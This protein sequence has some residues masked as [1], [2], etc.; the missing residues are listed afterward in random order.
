MPAKK[1]IDP[2][3]VEKLAQ[4]FCSMGEIAAVVGCDKSTISR[5]FA[6][7][8]AKGREKGK[9]LL[10]DLQWTAAKKGNIA[11]LIWLGKQFLDQKEKQEVHATGQTVLT[12]AEKIVT[13]RK[14]AKA[15]SA[16]P[17]NRIDAIAGGGNGNGHSSGD[18]PPPDSS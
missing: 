14:E 3:I 6:T 18:G 10:R 11:M 5:R 16:R 12:V 2:K 1:D 13:E 15:L 7:E 9:T 17:V 4:R 8:V